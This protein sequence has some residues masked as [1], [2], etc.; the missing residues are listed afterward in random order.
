KSVTLMAA[1]STKAYQQLMGVSESDKE[2]CARLNRKKWRFWVLNILGAIYVFMAYII[3]AVIIIISY[4]IFG[5]NL[6]ES[7]FFNARVFGFLLFLLYLIIILGVSS[8]FFWLYGRVSFAE[9]SLANENR[10]AFSSIGRS[11]YLSRGEGRKIQ[12]VFTIGT[13]I[14]AILWIGVPSLILSIISVLFGGFWLFYAL[15]VA[16]FSSLFQIAKG[17]I[18]YYLVCHKDGADLNITTT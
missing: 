11:W 6:Q 7:A 16:I 14:L 13:A 10:S 2:I 5:L 9:L 12:L 4:L 18:Y 3:C 15:I 1:I 17:V 8:L